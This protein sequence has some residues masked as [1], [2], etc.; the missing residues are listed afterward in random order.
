VC[1]TE[2]F[3]IVV[4]PEGENLDRVAEWR[5]SIDAMR[6]LNPKRPF[7][8]RERWGMHKG[9]N[10]TVLTS[11]G[12][13]DVVQRVPG[14]PEWSELVVVAE[15]YEVEGQAVLVMNRSTP[16]RPQAPARFSPGPRRHRGDRAALRPVGHSIRPA[17]GVVHLAAG[18]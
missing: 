6:K 7:G 15:Q 12:Q 4:S 14:L 5:I 13:I 17:S 11:P 10:A 1:T 3:D 9:S 18:S 2:D 8:S 16:D